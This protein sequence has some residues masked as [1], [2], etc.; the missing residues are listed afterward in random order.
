MNKNKKIVR[1]AAWI[2]VLIIFII[3][4]LFYLALPLHSDRV[5]YIPKGS[6]NHTI[7]YLEK[8]NFNTGIIDK[9]ILYLLGKPQA[10]WI[11]LKKTKM[12]KLDFLY[13]LTTSKAAL[14]KITIIPGETNYFIF[15]QI[16]NKLH[17]KNFYCNIDEGFLKPDT[18]FLPIGMSPEKV[19]DY[20]YNVSLTY[21]KQISD[22]IFGKFE[23]SK[24][25]KYLIVASIIQKEAANA[26]EMKY[27]SAVIYNRLFK[28][29]KLQMD[30]ALNY[31]K[32]SHMKVTPEMIKNDK[33]SF[34]TYKFY[35][36][37][38]VAVCIPSTEA[39]IAA[40]FPAK[41]NYLYFVKCGKHHL[42]A[43]N[44]KAH[45]RNIGKCKNK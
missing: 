43:T 14:V 30:G 36:L 32:Y 4:T 20:L 45:L 25:K 34:N 3:F 13:K 9:I 7:D 17:L 40:I 6:V 33:S 23:Y 18:Y 29:M 12:S 10:G 16:E 11:D 39:V 5:V 35:G 1:I 38:K 8:N 31:G 37:P 41:V 2:E 44:Y 27:I 22:K 24:Y 19:C 28:H 42:F 21:H 15:K 26:N